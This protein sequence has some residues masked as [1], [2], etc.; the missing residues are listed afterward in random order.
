MSGREGF[1][2]VTVEALVDDVLV[3]IRVPKAQAERMGFYDSLA[4]VS[5]PDTPA[6]LCE[7]GPHRP[8]GS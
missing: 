6:E 4:D 3:T 7:R 1:P 5:I 2:I 8:E